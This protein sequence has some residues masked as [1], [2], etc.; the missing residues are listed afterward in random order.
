[1]PSSIAAL[2]AA[3][4]ALVMCLVFS[5]GLPLRASNENKHCESTRDPQTISYGGYTAVNI[6]IPQ[7]IL[8]DLSRTT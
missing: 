4:I 7:K 3:M 6:R 1:M 5:C 8:S 2:F